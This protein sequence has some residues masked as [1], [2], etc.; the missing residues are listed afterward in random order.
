MAKWIKVESVIKTHSSKS[1]FSSS[2]HV[3]KF[4]NTNKKIKDKDIS[5]TGLLII[6]IAPDEIKPILNSL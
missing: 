5:K 6:N 2:L 3:W 4:E 1:I